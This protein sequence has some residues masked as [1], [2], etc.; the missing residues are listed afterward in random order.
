MRS[1]LFVTAALAATFVVQTVHAQ[2]VMQVQTG[3]DGAKPVP[4]KPAADPDDTPEEIAKDAQRDLKDSRFYNK[5]GATRAQYDADWQDCRLIARGSRTPSGTIPYYY[6]PQVISPVA[7]GVGGLFGSLI[8]SAIAQGAQRRENRRSCLLIKGWRLVEVPNATALRVGAMTDDQRSEYFNS[9]VGA[10]TV[11][12]A[13]TERKSFELAADSNLKLEAP[14]A[15]PG[16]LWL[17]KNVDPKAPFTLAPNE[18]AIVFGFR[19]PDAGSAGRSGSVAVTRYDANV[20]DLLYRPKDW[21][22]IG[23]KTTYSLLAKSKDKKATYEV[24]VMR[25]TPGDYVLSGSAV[26][27]VLITNSFCFGA[28]T[29]HVGAG[30]TLYVGDFVPYMSAKMTNGERLNTIAWAS[31]LEDAR[32]VLAGSQG[33]LAQSLKPAALRDRATYA[34]SAIVMDRWDLPGAEDLPE[35]P[36]QPAVEAVPAPAVATPATR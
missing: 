21:K 2:A 11:D 6:N 25:V 27:N 33:A 23:D 10:E 19:R 3:G 29:F 34:C 8:G 20:R 4:Q 9:I 31:H 15:G 26:G 30:E 1:R 13:I 5:P 22:K 36:P 32:G 14:L 35:L 12:G 16:A 24:Q 7:A 18:G 28:P 17:G